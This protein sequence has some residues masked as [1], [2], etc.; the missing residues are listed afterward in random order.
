MLNKAKDKMI[1][2]VAKRLLETKLK[3]YGEVTSLS[4]ES[5]NNRMVMEFHPTGESAPI[6]VT[7]QEYKIVETDDGVVIRLES[8]TSD[9]PWVANIL[10][11]FVEGYEVPLEGPAA[12][13]ADWIL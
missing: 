3:R 8:L 4:V 9:R 11:D 6:Q 13:R 12:K 1:A 5:K 2:T 10:E 7:I